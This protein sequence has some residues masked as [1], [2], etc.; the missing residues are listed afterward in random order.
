M[1]EFTKSVLTK[2]SFDRLLFKKELMKAKK[3]LSADE[4]HH[5]R[6]WCQ[7]RFGSVYGDV[8]NETFAGV[9]Y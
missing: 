5:L 8:I 1:L 4:L 7:Q 6:T 2:V 9:A 3:W